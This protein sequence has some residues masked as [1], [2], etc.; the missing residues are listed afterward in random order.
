M[1]LNRVLFGISPEEATFARRGFEQAT[2]EKRTHLE[3]IGRTF[4]SGYLTALDTRDVESLADR[5]NQTPAQFRGFVFEGA[6]MGLALTDHVWP[7]SRRFRQ[8]LNG[9]AASHCYMLHVG[10]GWAVARLPWLRRNIERARRNQDPYLG[11]LILDG[12]GF[13]EGYFHWRSAVMEMRRPRTLSGYAARAFD[14]G[15]GRSLWFFNGADVGRVNACIGRFAVERRADLW[16]GIGLAATYAGGVREEELR[17]L[18]EIADEYRG[19][20][21]QGAAFA[22]KARQFAGIATPHTDAACRILCGMPSSE[23][24]SITDTAFAAVHP[25]SRSE[26]P[27]ETWRSQIR[28]QFENHHKICA[29]VGK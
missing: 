2:P 25:G 3:Q 19:H 23:A 11:W 8:F 27:Y 6:A 4:I 21:A 17:P 1:R 10:Y 26:E 9:P 13:H 28:A 24:A 7:L 14:Q 18:F 5:L 20:L 15:L 16:S 12:Y 22:A 29:I